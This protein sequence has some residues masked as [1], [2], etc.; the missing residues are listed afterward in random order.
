VRSIYK[1]KKANEIIESEIA[2]LINAFKKTIG[3]L[4]LIN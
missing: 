1:T 4:I 3:E 2:N